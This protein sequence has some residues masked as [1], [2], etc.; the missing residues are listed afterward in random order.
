MVF[1]WY[2]AVDTKYS[3]ALADSMWREETVLSGTE[4][5]RVLS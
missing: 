4:L 3:V 1:P 2:V 5:Q